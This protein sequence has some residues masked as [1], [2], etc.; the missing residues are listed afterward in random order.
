MPDKVRINISRA[1]LL[2]IIIYCSFI[3]YNT[4][5]LS[6]KEQKDNIEKLEQSIED[7]KD[8]STPKSKTTSEVDLGDIDYEIVGA[9]YVPKI[10][11][12]IAVYNS[13]DEEAIRRGVGILETTGTLIPKN[14]QN[15]I[16]TTHNGDNKR[17]LF[18][19]LHKLDIDDI[20]FTKDQNGDIVKYKVDDIKE[21]L[22]TELF[23][24]MIYDKSVSKMTLVTCTPVGINSHRLLVTATQVHEEVKDKAEIEKELNS[25][26]I[27]FS[28]YE[29]IIL[30]I[31]VISLIFFVSTFIKRKERREL[32]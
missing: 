9:L 32:E 19:N 15:V 2:I 29:L 8:N 12:K 14:G 31:L 1:I 25:N 18:M 10:N 11:L 16:V 20:F 21:V 17:D 3:M 30:A 24:S 23:D 22:P 4:K 28:N 5:Y 6:V 7:K 26:K 13:T 27:T